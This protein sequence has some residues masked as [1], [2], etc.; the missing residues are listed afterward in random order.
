M[1]QHN[2]SIIIA[3]DLDGTIIDH[4]YRKIAAAK[5]YGYE[6]SPR[7]TVS[8]VIDSIVKNKEHLSAIKREV[9]DEEGVG[10]VELMPRAIEVLHD[11]REK[12]G[13]V[14]VIS[15]RSNAHIT[16]NAKN[17][18]EKYLQN[19]IEAKHT[20][21]V[22]TD[23]EKDI[24]AQ[25]LGVRVYIDDRIETLDVMESVPHRFLFD[26]YAHHTKQNKYQRVTN[27]DEFA[28]ALARIL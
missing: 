26:P 11:L 25:K 27:W 7:D 20:F 12:F 9:Y 17:R 2:N 28:Q 10:D 14:A 4:T 24:I 6:L 1:T 22:S 5:K 8:V 18:I 23:E 21:F 15:R 19:S 13:P 16:D 3:S